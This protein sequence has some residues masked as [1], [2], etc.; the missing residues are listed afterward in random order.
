MWLIDDISCSDKY[1]SSAL[2]SVNDG[3]QAVL[4]L[5]LLRAKPRRLETRAVVKPEPRPEHV[6]NTPPASVSSSSATTEATKTVPAPSRTFMSL[7]T[8]L[9]SNIKYMQPQ[10][11]SV[12]GVGASH[13]F[14]NYWTCTGGLGEVLDIMPCQEQ[15]ITLIHRYFE[16]VD[17]VY[18][19]IHRV[20]FFQEFEAMLALMRTAEDAAGQ[21]GS[22]HQDKDTTKYE[23]V[24]VAPDFVA[25]VLIMMAL[26]MQFTPTT[27]SLTPT[28]KKQMAEFYVS[29]S[30]QALRVYSYMNQASIRSIQAMVLI[31]YFL[32]NNN[33]CSDG[34]AFSGVLLKQTY[35]LGLHRDPDIG[36]CG[37]VC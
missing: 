26:G 23:R 36:E 30:N 20:S 5:P 15:T 19:L 24:I 16:C 6:I 7:S 31:T 17:P 4:P 22:G 2:T 25:L 8:G 1:R 33:H 28:E 11:C 9:L 27:G 12:F 32:I 37:C 13:P 14:A 29:G 21:T 35:A 10:E 18:P 34:W 3:P